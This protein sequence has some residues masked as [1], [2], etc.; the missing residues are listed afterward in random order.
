MSYIIYIK[1]I[2]YKCLQ[3]QGTR[4]RRKYNWKQKLT[5]LFNMITLIEQ[6]STNSEVADAR[7]GGA[8]G[9]NRPP[10]PMKVSYR[11]SYVLHAI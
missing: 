7:G 1:T 3:V 8:H 2:L 6:F 10:S 9:G 11:I 4:L 5:T